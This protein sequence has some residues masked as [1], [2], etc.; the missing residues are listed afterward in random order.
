MS[1]ERGG[2]GEART[3]KA[4]NE[5][6]WKQKKWRGDEGQYGLDTETKEDSPDG[7]RSTVAVGAAVLDGGTRWTFAAAL[8]E[9]WD[10]LGGQRNPS[11]INVRLN[12]TASP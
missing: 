4:K 12:L 6:S 1:A 8:G 2:R 9:R 10:G 5:R 7:L 3:I 11:Y